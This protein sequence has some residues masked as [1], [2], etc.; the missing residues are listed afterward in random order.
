[1]TRHDDPIRSPISGDGVA[2]LVGAILA[3]AA[4]RRRR[5][6]AR[7][8]PG[9]ERR[10]VRPEPGP[11]AS[12]GDPARS[13]RRRSRRRSAR[14]RRTPTRA[15]HRRPRRS[16]TTPPGP[17]PIGYG[18]GATCGV[19]GL[20]CFTRDVAERLHDVAPRAGP[21][22]RLGHA[23]V[24]PGLQLAAE[25]LLRRR[26]DHARRVR[27][28]RGSRPSRQLRRRLG[29]RGRRR[30]DLLADEA[31]RPAGTRHAFGRCDVATLQCIYDM[32]N[33]E[34]QVFDL[35]RPDDGPDPERVAAADPGRQPDDAD[36]DASG[37]LDVYDAIVPPA[38]RQPGRGPDRDAPAPGARRDD[39]DDRRHD[40]G[41]LGGRDLRPRPSGS[42]AT[43]EYRAVFATPS[44]EG[45][46]GD[47]SP[48]GPGL[49]EQRAARRARRACGPTAPCAV[50][51]NGGRLDD[52]SVTPATRA[53]R[54]RRCSRSSSRPAALRT[55]R[56]ATDRA[57]DGR[58]VADARRRRPRRATAA[59]TAARRRPIRRGP[60]RRAE[61]P[62]ALSRGRGRRPG[63]PG[64]S[65]SFTW[66]DGGSDSPWLPGTPIT[67]GAGERLTVTARQPDRRDRQLGRS[68]RPG[69]DDRT[70]PA[71][72]RLGD[73]AL[74]RSRS[75]PAGTG[76]WSVQLTVQFADDLGSATYYWQVTV[77]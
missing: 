39:L 71:R 61:P 28:R 40:A 68:P 38:R 67:V 70:A 12:A 2:A 64:S 60:V 4:D 21:R 53:S 30:P 22:L 26:D 48:D 14:P 33:I 63:R 15:A 19:N 74:A 34:R 17:N 58:L 75:R 23:Q 42:P 11:A 31:V 9:A 35:P 52:R 49:R 47:T 55:W 25:R 72:S 32:L 51:R 10:P 5:R 62:A 46:N 57:V 20:A 27:P 1:M 36:R 66:D 65:G 45:L 77:R 73:G 29:L 50:T 18:A 7:P 43:T 59:P 16:P 56:V 76:T 6:G 13:R 37:S 54:H 8:G 24:V 3:L 44:S 41:R 69:R